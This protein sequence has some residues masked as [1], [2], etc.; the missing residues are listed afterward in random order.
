MSRLASANTQYPDP[1]HSELDA[2]FTHNITLVEMHPALVSQILAGYQ[3]DPWWARLHRQI[4][5]NNKLG[6]D[7][8]TL[9][10]V[11]DSTPSAD[12]DPY[13]IPRPAG[14]EDLPP[15]FTDIQQ[16]LEGL[17]AP[18]KSKRLYHVNKI[19]NVHRL[20]ISPSV[21]PDILAVAHGKGHPGFS[22]CYEII[23]RS[24][25]VRGLTKL[26]Q[27]FI[28][29]CPQCLA[30]QT[31]RHAPYGSLQPIESPPV[32]FFTLTLDF[33]LT[34]PLLKESHN[35]IMLVTCKFSK[36]VTLI[37]GADTWSA[38]QWA[39]VFF[40]RLDLIDWGLLGEL[41]TDRDPKFLSKFWT[42]LFKKL[43]VK[44]LYS[45]VYHPQTDRSSER[46]NQTVEIALRFFVHA[47][48]DLSRWPKVLSKIQSLLN[49]SSSSTTGKTPNEV[50]YGFSPRR[51]L[52]LYVTV[53]RP[54][55]YVARTEAADAI[56]FA[57]VNHKKYYDRS[58]QPLFMKVGDWAMLKLHKGYS[59]SSSVGVTKKLTQ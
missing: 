46:T 20:C 51:P 44:L 15:S 39:H 33:V 40:N 47:M 2:L 19:T 31:R 52:D 12:S 9:L 35:A 42:P 49:N 22:S 4:Q 58:H 7:A 48:E 21:A 50:A 6:A 8:A 43:E 13:L 45:T 16:T 5:A 1:Q 10:F 24:W 28:R 56:S 3:T 55:T 14:D 54:D 32:P 30:L 18:D 38:E 27:A 25:Y 11:I 37:E 53:T 17:L 29:H 26:L 41:I 59:I 23:S 57:F 34:L 36:R